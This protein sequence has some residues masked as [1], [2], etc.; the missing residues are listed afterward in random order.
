MA[1]THSIGTPRSSAS[2]EARALRDAELVEFHIAFLAAYNVIFPRESSGYFP[3]LRFKF[4]NG[5]P[6]KHLL[7][8]RIHLPAHFFLRILD[9]YGKHRFFPLLPLVE[10][11]L[12]IIVP[13]AIDLVVAEDIPLLPRPT[14]CGHNIPRRLFWYTVAEP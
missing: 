9:D 7:R 3:Q 1:I 2:F 14:V 5:R 6:N 13:C 11:N 12:I 10:Q 8:I 4:D